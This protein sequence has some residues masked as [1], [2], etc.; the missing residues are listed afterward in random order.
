MSGRN[1]LAPKEQAEPKPGRNLFK[2]LNMSESLSEGIKTLVPEG[3]E[4]LEKYGYRPDLPWER[5][6]RRFREYYEGQAD[7]E[8]QGRRA[9]LG[10]FA[11][12]D[13]TENLTSRAKA[14][15]AKND[16]KLPGRNTPEPKMGM[17]QAFVTGAADVGRLVP[18][19][20]QLVQSMGEAA[21][22]D[23]SLDYSKVLDASTT[24]ALEDRPMTTRGGQIAT[25]LAPGA[26]ITK[27]VTAAPRIAGALMSPAVAARLAGKSLLAQ[28]ARYTG[29]GA[30][31]G[32]AGVA[33]YYLY[34]TAA[35]AGNVAK[36]EGQETPD[37]GQRLGYANS[38][39][40]T[41]G[42]LISAAAGPLV[43]G[44]YR[45]GR[46]AVAGTKNLATTG[47]LRRAIPQQGAKPQIVGTR[48]DLF[49]P[50]D[51]QGRVMAGGLKA[52]QPSPQTGRTPTEEAYDL[53]LA[54]GFD[55]DKTEA[56]VKL[57]SYDRY[58]NV[59]EMLFELASMV[60]GAA[61]I[62]QL[63]VA[64][65]RVGGDS[66]RIFRQGFQARNAEMPDRIRVALRDALGLSGDDLED[67]GR[68]MAAKA[69][70]ASSEGYTAAY[71]R[72]VS[73]ESWAK[74][75]QRLLD[76]TDG[77]SPNLTND[78][79][80]GIAAAR[81]GA[82]E[83]RATANGDKAQLE[84]ARQLDELA[85]ALAGRSPQAPK[86]STHALDFLDRGFGSRI[87]DASRGTQRS[88]IGLQRAIRQ[89]GLD[90]DTGLNIPR[91][92]YAQHMAAQKALTWA[93]ERAAKKAVSLR[94]LKNQFLAAQ[95]AA[96]EAFEEGIGEGR[97][98][99]DQSLVMGWLRGS[100]DLIEMADNPG[101]LIRQIYG[102]ERQR[103]K[104]LEMMP[105]TAQGVTKPGGGRMTADEAGTGDLG[106][107]TK[108]IR[109][110]VGGK[111]SDGKGTVE[112]LF[113]RQRRMLENQG[114]VSGG[115]QT[116]NVNEAITAQGGLV[117]AADAI[118]R[119]IMN[120]A[121]A[122]RNAAL[123]AVSNAPIFRPA[124]FKP[125]VNRELGRILATR[126]R[127]ELIV[128]IGE[129]RARAIATGKGP[130]PPAGAAPPPP[131]TPPTGGGRGPRNAPPPA[132][133]GAGPIR[134]G[135][136]AGLRIDA[137]NAAAQFVGGA[138]GTGLLPVPEDTP[139]E[140]RLAIAAA[141]G[142]GAMGLGRRMR[143]VGKPRNALADTATAGFRGQSRG[144]N[145]GRFRFGPTGKAFNP[146]NAQVQDE[147]IR[148]SGGLVDERNI[149]DLVSIY[150]DDLV[151]STPQ[152]IVDDLRSDAAM[153]MKTGGIQMT[154]RDV[155]Y[156]AFA[157]LMARQLKP[158]RGGT[159][160]ILTAGIGGGGRGPRKPTVGKPKRDIGTKVAD[161]TAIAALGIAP[162]AEGQDGGSAE[163]Q[164][165]NER[166]KSATQR[167]ADVD[168]SI[169]QLE[170]DKRL[171]ES[172]ASDPRKVQ[173]LLDRRGFD[174]GPKGLDGRIGPDTRKAI[175]D[176]IAKI[177]SEIARKGGEREKAAAEV[178]KARKGVK[179][180]NMRAALKAAEPN[181]AG[182]MATKAAQGAAFL[183]A[184]YAAYR[185][186]K[187]AVK[188]YEPVAKAAARR[189]NAL[190]NPGKLT[191]AKTGPNALNTRAANINE[192]WKQGGA[193]ERVP[194]QV[195]AQGTWS[196]R[197]GAKEPSKLFKAPR[198]M[199][200]DVKFMA[201]AGVEAGGTKYAA[202]KFAEE[203]DKAEADMEKALK[204]GDD[205]AFKAALQRKKSADGAEAF[206]RVLERLGYGAM[207]GRALS[208]LVRYPAVRANVNAADSERAL[209]LQAM[210]KQKPGAKKN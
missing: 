4:D 176:N 197:P 124:I 203:S 174:L 128:V 173:D 114:R 201:G 60:D 141:G 105:N 202:D 142:L 131:A 168:K 207:A 122:A 25:L 163:L 169:A 159:D 95:K 33:D 15:A 54:K 31:L 135:G 22:G 56:L 20:K 45:T 196:A 82:R 67:F 53:L 129:I 134:A 119:A 43:S 39:V 147:I 62:D 100:E 194:F 28:G 57:V 93:A 83:A 23:P 181:A 36:L 165:A 130:K 160:D 17:G 58:A 151:E 125:E 192:F 190:V 153:N 89:S 167:V 182:D 113:D 117:R 116:G 172:P 12:N 154:Q 63:A 99:I 123:W 137:G 79:P 121:E 107:Q 7:R 46:A 97:S 132:P 186:R 178:E 199:P 71:G 84:A 180:A 101:S 120:P 206:L 86:L 5:Q 198:Y 47:T 27:G 205:V 209:L 16:F 145:A 26:A 108:R 69:K 148:T 166:V 1:L 66:N 32:G 35:E 161:A 70:E 143:S 88:L 200:N 158:M 51:V 183:A 175:A 210:T 30:V 64:L 80:D 152:Q 189:A 90:A 73:D 112:S 191:A 55:P 8:L 49:T 195:D 164:A 188:A 77:F 162:P 50:T 29:R 110:L 18:G 9:L 140:Q 42:G 75:Y 41:P 208:G 76:T 157:E 96:D 98:V 19:G 115:S 146:Y 149:D 106:D 21:V 61:D 139:I 11:E 59:D 170:A 184:T 68:Q 204:A 65:A 91:T 81:A 2:P 85:G 37:L 138:A 52:N 126:G 87:A 187:G 144:P 127:D 10:P 72:Q 179:D 74:I 14:L 155:E 111:R 133:T 3:R 13:T 38:Q 40:L 193:G 104:L 44:A 94:D 24:R 102:S 78:V 103:Q 118:A 177:E 156:V 109:A 92:I 185:F 171:L 136:F 6:S 150:M 34:N 48:S